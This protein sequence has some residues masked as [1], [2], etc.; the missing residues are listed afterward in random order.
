MPTRVRFRAMLR[1]DE[2]ASGLCDVV[3]NGSG[4]LEAS[5]NVAQWSYDSANC[6]DGGDDDA[7]ASALGDP[8]VLSA[9]GAACDGRVDG[10]AADAAGY[11]GGLCS[12]E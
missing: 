7:V 11:D 10:V 12:M 5:A 6:A 3:A 4:L 8:I 2:L 1:V 9:T